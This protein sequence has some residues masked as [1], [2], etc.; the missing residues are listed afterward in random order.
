LLGDA[1]EALTGT[2]IHFMAQEHNFTFCA[3]DWSGF[4]S[5]DVPNTIGVLGDLSK[6]ADVP[7]RTDQG[8]VDFTYLGRLMRHP[9]GFAADPAF[10][11]GGHPAFDNSSLFYDGNS[12]GGILGSTLTAIAPDFQRAALGVPGINFSLLLTRSSDW[13]VYALIFNPAYKEEKSRP[14]A[15]AL[16][17]MLWDRAE[18][19]GWAANMTTSPPPN[20]PAHTVLMQVAR[21]D[22][23]VSPL[24]AQ[25][26]ARMNGARTNA[27]PFAPGVSDDKQALYGIP[28]IASYPYSGSAIIIWEPGG[29]L[30]RVPKQPLTNIP[31]HPGV[32]P[33]G[34]PRYTTAARAQKAAFLAP[35]GAVIDVCGG[36]FCQAE[37]DP[38]RP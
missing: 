18:P 35:N 37:K 10:Q 27:T 1:K 3:A 9:L 19:S 21:G 13:K 28:R 4:A 38:A 2:S 34:D 29:G 6:F 20:T 33:H 14:L 15:L 23:Q 32:D 11:V 12:Q 30:A 7:D 25:I 17:E 8:I 5:E 16:I 22:H 26:E 24:A 31:D 36:S